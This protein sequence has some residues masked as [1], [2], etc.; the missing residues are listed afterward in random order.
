[1]LTGPISGV[2]AGHYIVGMMND[3]AVFSAA[4]FHWAVVP[5]LRPDIASAFIAIGITTYFW[6]QNTKGIEESSEKALD[7]MKIT[8]VMVVIL[9]AWGIFT[10]VHRGAILPPLPIPSNLHLPKP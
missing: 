1:V 8:T 9:L 10:V 6:W 4:R 3:L 2:S 7:I 5:H